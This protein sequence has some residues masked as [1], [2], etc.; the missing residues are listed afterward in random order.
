MY[1]DYRYILNMNLCVPEK[2]TQ[3]KLKN[4]K[5]PSNIKRIIFAFVK[6]EINIKIVPL[7]EI[8]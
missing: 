7:D 1:V 3:L 2:L 4:I 5:T 6:R 8:R